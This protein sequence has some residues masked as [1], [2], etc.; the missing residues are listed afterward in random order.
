M[1]L[2]SAALLKNVGMEL[3]RPLVSCLITA[4]LWAWLQVPLY[5]SQIILHALV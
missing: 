2:R 3:L 1:S 4:V 5:E